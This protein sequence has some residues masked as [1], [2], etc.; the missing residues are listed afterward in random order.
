MAPFF[1]ACN[2][3]PEE[4]GVTAFMLVPPGCVDKLPIR[5]PSHAT[6]NLL[7]GAKQQKSPP[8]EG[9]LDKRC[10]EP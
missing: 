10:C 7:L 8:S 3:P 2:R 4:Q 9:G 1:I 6:G 5:R